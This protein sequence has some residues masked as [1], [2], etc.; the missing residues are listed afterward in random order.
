[1]VRGPSNGTL[2]ACGEKYYED[3]GVD[4]ETIEQV[5]PVPPELDADARP[6]TLVMGADGRPADYY[7]WQ[8]GTRKD[9]LRSTMCRQI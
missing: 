8:D 7:E 5:T 9:Y 6:P 1:M 4:P 3:R 2:Q